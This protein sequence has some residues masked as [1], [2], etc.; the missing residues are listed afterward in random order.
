M[1]KSGCESKSGHPPNPGTWHD[2]I[3]NDVHTNSKTSFPLKNMLRLISGGRTEIRI[4]NTSR[5]IRVR[6]DVQD[7]CDAGRRSGGLFIYA[8]TVALTRP[9]GPVCKL[10]Y[11]HTLTRTHA[12]TC[13]CVSCLCRAHNRTETVICIRTVKIQ[14][15]SSR[16][17]RRRRHEYNA[18]RDGARG[19]VQG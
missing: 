2:T 18:T 19:G 17:W 3:A 10:E 13:V 6:Y 14:F 12:H 16:E 1:S 4:S 7:E 8:E 5:G 11:A 9:E 15:E